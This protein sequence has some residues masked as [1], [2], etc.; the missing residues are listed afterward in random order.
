MLKR[1][2]LVKLL[3]SVKESG[4]CAAPWSNS[5]MEGL[6]ALWEAAEG[7]DRANRLNWTHA[8]IAKAGGKLHAA[9]NALREKQNADPS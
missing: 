8:R 4:S 3:E 6:L 5:L 1:K 9:L 2:E 7:L